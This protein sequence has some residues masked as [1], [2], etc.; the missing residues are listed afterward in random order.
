MPLNGNTLRCREI[1]RFRAC[2]PTDCFSQAAVSSKISSRHYHFFWSVFDLFDWN[3]VVRVWKFSSPCSNE[4]SK[5]FMAVKI[6][7]DKWYKGRDSI[8]HWLL[9]EVHWCEKGINQS[10][11]CRFWT[12][13]VTDRINRY[14]PQFLFVK[15]P[16]SFYF[17]NE[18]FALSFIFV[19]F[20]IPTGVG[21]ID[22]QIT[23]IPKKL[24]LKTGQKLLI[25][26]IFR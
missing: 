25:Q 20:A 13:C 8:P 22:F 23:S 9:R 16:F 18:G 26:G 10:N 4:L 3:F 7:H 12:L 19:Q 1:V 17:D 15:H 14:E 6:D 5:L 21:Y 11:S 2:L 24:T